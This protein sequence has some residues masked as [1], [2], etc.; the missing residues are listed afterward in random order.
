MLTKLA[1]ES[2][3]KYQK[4]LEQVESQY[5]TSD[6]EAITVRNGIDNY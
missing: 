1:A 6:I 2:K 4:C 5:K 3:D